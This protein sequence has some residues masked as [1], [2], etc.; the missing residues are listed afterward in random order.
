M[1]E[2]PGAGSAGPR[3]DSAPVPA[4]GHR[5]Y[6]RSPV[7]RRCLGRPCE[8]CR[9]LW[10]GFVPHS[11]QQR[12]LP[13]VPYRGCTRADA[14]WVACGSRWRSEGTLRPWDYGAAPHLWVTFLTPWEGLCTQ[15]GALHPVLGVKGAAGSGSACQPSPHGFSPGASRVCR[16]C[17]WPSGVLTPVFGSI[18]SWV[19]AFVVVGACELFM[20]NPQCGPFARVGSLLCCVDLLRPQRC[21]Q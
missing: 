15:N 6:E 8:Q 3:Q 4:L 20:W 11:Q 21:T 17:C 1:G 7:V 14:S 19:G 13:P 5:G 12:S 2:G 18:S 16:D 10:L 9:V